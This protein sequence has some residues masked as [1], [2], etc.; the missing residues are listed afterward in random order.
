MSESKI[1]AARIFA[2]LG[3][4]AFFNWMSDE[5]YLKIL[6]KFKFGTKL[7]LENPQTFNEKLQWLK[8]YNQRPEYTM[9]VDKYAV[10]K[11][12]A[13]LI[14]EEY[15]IPTL[16]VWDRFD[17]IDFDKLPNQFV[18]KCTHNSGGIV[19]C[20]DKSKFDIKSARKFLTKCL[21]NNYY[22][23]GREW[24]YKDV[25]RK[26]IAEK[27]MTDSDETDSFTDYKFFCF[28]GKVD[29]VMVCIER[30]TG[31]PKFYFF[32]S[33]WNLKRYNKL[34]KEAPENFTIE[35]PDNINEMF[36]IAALLSQ[37]IPF[38][39]VDL[40][41]SN[42]QIYFGELTFYPSSG[43]EKSYLKETDIHFGNLVDLSKII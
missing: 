5:K 19:I 7:D 20:K 21:K 12:V 3:H 34:G 10:K 22:Y 2:A 35:A 18:L 8:L 16:G 40:Y 41:N 14:G 23:S 33:N 25:P 28:D 11:Y 37:N 26:I 6:W 27:Y 29:C 36:K 38:I 13:D 31:T 4:R 9:M 30:N 43:F 42:G 15:I 1:T 24:P 17:D 39:R 32:D